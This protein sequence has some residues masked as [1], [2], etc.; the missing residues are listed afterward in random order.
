MLKTLEVRAGEVV[1]LQA[2]LLASLQ[3]ILWQPRPSP[4]SPNF[5]G[6][7]TIQSYKCTAVCLRFDAVHVSVVHFQFSG[8][9]LA[10][11]SAGR[12]SHG[13]PLRLN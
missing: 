6:R 5:N 8:F 9:L 2:P 7:R 12:G 11:L 4:R 1:S 13:G 3:T 10:S